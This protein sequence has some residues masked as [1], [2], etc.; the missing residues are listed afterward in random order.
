MKLVAVLGSSRE[1]SVSKAVAER[2]IETYKA[3]GGEVVLFEAEKMEIQGCKGCGVC[4]KNSTDCV[5]NDDMQRYY[6]ELHSCSALLVTAPN[7][8]SM[9]AGHMITFMNRHYCMTTAD[10]PQRLK[11]GI[12]FAAVF[13]Q[14]APQDYPKYVPHY[15]WYISTFTGKGMESVGSIT[16]GGDS[17]LSDGGEIMTAA[18]NL[19]KALL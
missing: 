12:K 16:A 5:I 4:R 9:P 14:G 11:P 15:D 17:D 2:I 7:Y 19:G 13:A 10:R 6:D 18:E 8:Y 1:N 3:N